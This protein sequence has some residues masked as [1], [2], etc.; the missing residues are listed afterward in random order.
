M[1]DRNSPVGV[2]DSGVGGISTLGALKR[3]LPGEH[4]LY[5]GDTRNAPYG[6]KSTGEVIACVRRVV[7]RLLRADIKALVIACNTASG[8]AAATLRAELS[9][10]VIA[11]EPA[12]K[13]AEE[14]WQGGRILVMATPLTL[15]QEKFL[16][17]ME[18]FGAHAAPLPCPGL[19]EL[20]EAEDE[21]GARRYLEK[22]LA[23]W[24]LDSV[25]AVVLGCTHY[26][27]LKPM[28][29]RMLPDRIRITDGNAGTARQLRRVLSERDLLR[30]AG[31]GAVRMETSGDPEV[32]LPVMRRLFRKALEI[33]TT[34]ISGGK[35]N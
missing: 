33:N 15:R 4:F 17:L 26:V 35:A 30:T 5:Y 9:L 2:F 14:A 28:L 19:M 27:F 3:E 8:A 12:L 11:M 6:T 23:G 21:A 16:G 22:L 34:S 24:D 7:E 18:R 10:P 32:I 29:R 13:P 25:D 1:G 31:P 20:V